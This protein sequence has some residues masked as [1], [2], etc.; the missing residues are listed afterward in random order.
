MRRLLPVAAVLVLAGCGAVP[1]QPQPVSSTSATR[2]LQRG[3]L[4]GLTT[5]ELG[6]R[7][8]QPSFQVRE[9]PGVKLQWANPSCV[10]DAFLYASPG[11]SV[12]RVAYVDARR[13][14]GDPTDRSACIA[15]IAAR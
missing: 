10:L 9:G 2:P 6:E 1:E 5:D 4:I 3:D 11:S 8:G 13:P 14:S 15:A 12:L 7:F